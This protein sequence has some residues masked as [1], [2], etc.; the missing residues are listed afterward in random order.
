MTTTIASK[1]PSTADM[2]KALQAED[3]GGEDA[4]SSGGSTETPPEGAEADDAGART[5]SPDD[6]G[7]VEADGVEGQ[8]EDVDGG[9]KD[10]D[11]T[12]KPGEKASKPSRREK[13]K[14]RAQSAEKLAQERGEQLTEAVGYANTFRTEAAHFKG[15]YE[16]LLAT[17]KKEY[18]YEENATARELA[19][20]KL[21]LNQRR[22]KDKLVDSTAEEA[23][24]TEVAQV[25]RQ[26]REEVTSEVHRL[27]KKY[28]ALTPKKLAAAYVTALDILDEGE[29]EPTMEDV[30]KSLLPIASASKTKAQHTAA[31]AQHTVNKETVK[32]IQ[33]KGG[34]ARQN[35]SPTTENIA[36][37]LRAEEG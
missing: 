18:G 2:A 12:D 28:P 6:Q 16:A 9:D 7:K 11:Q 37:L 30:A 19:E 15:M 33:G 21:E 25:E 10:G 14:L 36:A 23:R 27:A 26:L 32:P 17:V 29:A 20:A 13:L 8:S 5:A 35:L 34:S 1:A 4:P 31:R 22:A 3:M 24:K